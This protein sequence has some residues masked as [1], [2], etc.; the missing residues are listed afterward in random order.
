MNST[1]Y[2]KIILLLWVLLI[3]IVP[4]VAATPCSF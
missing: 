3:F 4:A 1:T 2:L